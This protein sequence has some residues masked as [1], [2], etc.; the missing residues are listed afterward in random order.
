MLLC[1]T[2]SHRTAGFDLLDR[3]ERHAAAVTAA[4]AENT[5][6]FNGSVVLATCNRFEA[7]LDVDTDAAGAAGA[8][9]SAETVISAV[10]AASGVDADE[11][12]ASSA[13]ISDQGVAEHLFSV[14]SGLESVVVGEGEIAGQ[15]RRALDA[16]RASGTVSSELE[17]L[18]QVASR[19]SRGVKN[20]TGITSAGRSIVRLALDLAE[21]RITDWAATRVLLVGTG[22]Y[23]GASLAALRE[24]GVTDVH[25]YSPSGRAQKFAVA[26]AAGAVPAGGL[27][28]AIAASDL[29][30]TCSVAP[31]IILGVPELQAVIAAPGA[32]P[33]RLVIDLG[34]PRNVD[35]AVAHIDGVELLD[36]ETIS[37]HAPL[38]ELN[39]T[40]E[41]RAIVG[42]AAA[43]FAAQAAEHAVTPA[44]VAL[45]AHVFDVL[46]AEIAR[47]RSRGDSSEQTEAALRHLAGVLLH[48]PSVRARELARHGDASAFT[49]AANTLFGLDVE[50]PG[51]PGLAG[52]SGLAGVPGLPGLPPRD[53]RTGDSTPIS[54]QGESAVS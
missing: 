54:D 12:R 38:E 10:S 2:S 27:V 9:V 33:R 44:L 50:V 22:A 1:F 43:E 20:R 30:V 51:V 21:S 49:A 26:H 5:E 14:S 16:A 25:V 37:K 29:V 3:L 7:Y 42:D 17:R 52:S 48:T 39:A 8:A 18:F 35:P 11:L 46:D 4:L 53:L 6:L 36:L 23:A 13:V 24:R 28:D 34:L 31:D 40:D 47:A 41:A 15:V 32:L 45:R 19:T